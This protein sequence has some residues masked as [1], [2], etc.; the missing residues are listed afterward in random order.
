[1]PL[2]K[3]CRKAI[4][5][6]YITQVELRA[7]DMHAPEGVGPDVVMIGAIGD[8]AAAEGGRGAGDGLEVA[9][10]GEN[11]LAGL[12]GRARRGDEDQV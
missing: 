6:G 9:A 1:M 5:I 3:R 11:G 10:E 2:H 12:S 8:G 4:H 7:E